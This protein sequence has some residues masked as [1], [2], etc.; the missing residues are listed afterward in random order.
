MQNA[1]S[2]NNNQYTFSSIN[3]DDIQNGLN[4]ASGNISNSMDENPMLSTF[5]T[6]LGTDFTPEFL[7]KTAGL[8]VS[9]IA[10]DRFVCSKMKGSEDNNFLKKIANLGDSIAR[11][12]HIDDFTGEKLN[13]FINSNRFTKYFTND[14]AANP[15]SSLAKLDA[16]S[17]DQ[18][19]RNLAKHLEKLKNNPN[20]ANQVNS[21]SDSAKTYLQT[22]K[23]ENAPKETKQLLAVTDELISKGIDKIESGGIFHSEV[24]LSALR[25]QVKAVTT[26]IGET[27]L[28]SLF[29][30]AALKARSVIGGSF[31]LVFVS[32]F[33]N[34]A[35]KEAKEAPEGEKIS[36]FAHVFSSGLLGLALFEPSMKLM[37]KLGGN[38]Y[39]GMTKEARTALENLVKTTNSNEFLTQDAL[40]VANIQKDLLLKGV[41]QDEV[42]NLTGKT[43]QEAE[44]MAQKL[45][46]NGKLNLKFWEK[47]LRFLGKIFSAGLDT[48][49]KPFYVKLPL[50]GKVNLAR[51]KFPGTL[52]NIVR[53][54]MIMAVLQPLLEKPF[55]KIVH[56]IF[57]EP[58]EYLKKENGE[59]TDDNQSEQVSDNQQSETQTGL[60]T[61]LPDAAKVNFPQQ[62]N[63]QFPTVNT[64]NPITDSN[65]KNNDTRNESSLYVPSILVDNSY[66]NEN[67]AIES[68]RIRELI[69][70]VNKNVEKIEKSL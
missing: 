56:K 4:Y 13:N 51:P 26:G 24:N 11:K 7:A 19:S 65:I 49:E 62:G 18:Y 60:W 17:L 38:K 10:A 25:N 41:H 53:I 43:V 28:G 36:T 14:F 16:L 33:I 20:F 42:A 23:P 58:K 50:V 40:K 9:L 69:K 22:L 32:L 54:I 6:M 34:Q 37:Y 68:Q 5:K 57:G 15:R 30:K 1:V 47:P 64:S 3:Q 45:A 66:V 29:S 59:V 67:E 35:F 52:G 46:Q 8:S 39:R 21:L 31:G 61:D 12:L 27:T 70:S 48:L 63:N 2:T 44:N 55:E